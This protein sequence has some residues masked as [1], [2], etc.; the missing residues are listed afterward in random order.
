MYIIKQQ[1]IQSG[2]FDPAEDNVRYLFVD[3][4]G[5]RVSGINEDISWLFMCRYL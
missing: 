1:G 5:N 4:D 2:W 3:Q